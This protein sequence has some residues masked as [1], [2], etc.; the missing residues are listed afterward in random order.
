M[1]SMTLG[2]ISIPSTELPAT[3]PT[4]NRGLW[5]KRSISGTETR[6]NTAAEAMLTPVMA[7]KAALAATV[8]TPS[9]PLTLRSTA[10]ATW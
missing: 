2:G 3:T 7:A 9:P 1:I 10:F 4:A 6:V 5:P 8:A